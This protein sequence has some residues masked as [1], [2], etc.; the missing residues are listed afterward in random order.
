MTELRRAKSD[1]LA[2]LRHAR[3]V[4]TS[5]AQDIQTKVKQAFQIFWNDASPAT[6]HSF[7]TNLSNVID[8]LSGISVSSDVVFLGDKTGSR[9]SAMPGSA[10]DI[11]QTYD[12]TAAI[13]GED[14]DAE[15]KQRADAITGPGFINEAAD[16]ALLQY[17]TRT[18]VIPLAMRDDNF[19][20]WN[21]D[22]YVTAYLVRQNEFCQSVI[23]EGFVATTKNKRVARQWTALMAAKPDLSKLS[24]EDKQ[25]FLDQ[26]SLTYNLFLF[27]GQPVEARPLAAF[28]NARSQGWD[29]TGEEVGVDI[30]SL[31]RTQ[32]TPSK[33][34]SA[35][36]ARAADPD[37]FSFLVIVLSDL[38]ADPP[39]FEDFTTRAANAKPGE[40]VMWKW[41]KGEPSA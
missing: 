31:L 22:F 24:A 16:S 32:R 15:H 35:T 10:F 26:L 11:A 5:D 33:E 6:I 41:F 39:R 23:R 38:K 25:V 40:Q 21:Y 8:F 13:S 20:L 28:V 37:L 12:V 30:S 27:E 19:E 3:A 1:A 34:E 7:A 9:L 36:A 14:V 29:K 4:A 17:A 18:E 2:I